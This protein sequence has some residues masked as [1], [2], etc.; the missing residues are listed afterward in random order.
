MN[1]NRI[2]IPELDTNLIMIRRHLFLIIFLL[3]GMVAMAQT[4]PTD[5]DG[6]TVLDSLD[7]CPDKAGCAE[8][9]G[10]PCVMVSDTVFLSTPTKM[11]YYLSPVF[12]TTQKSVLVEDSIP[13]AGRYI[14]L[15]DSVQILLYEY[16]IQYIVGTICPETE[17]V[18]LCYAIYCDGTKIYKYR[19]VTRQPSRIPALWQTV[20]QPTYKVLKYTRYVKDPKGEYMNE[21]PAK[22]EQID[23]KEMV[24]EP[25]LAYKMVPP[26]FIIS[27]YAACVQE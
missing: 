24:K 11:G 2:F 26:Q 5:T 20:K 22:Y 12:Q 25:E 4:N 17:Q 19:I 27:K 7:Q 23:I 14:K 15:E 16:H 18:K 13:Q 10:C 9:L 6:D 21:Q 3:T 8:I 1:I